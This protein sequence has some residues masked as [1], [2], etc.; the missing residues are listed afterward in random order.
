MGEQTIL[1]G[2]LQTASILS[3]DKMVAEGVELHM[4]Q[5]LIS[6]DGKL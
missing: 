6:M 1:C 3:F 2:V 5:K 4:L